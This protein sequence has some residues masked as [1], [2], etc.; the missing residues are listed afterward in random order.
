[1][2]DPIVAI[3]GHLTFNPDTG[4]FRIN[5]W[6]LGLEQVALHPLVGRGFADYAGASSLVKLFLGQ[7]V[8][9][10]W[11]LLMLR[12]GIPVVVFLLLAMFV[13]LFKKKRVSSKDPYLNKMRTAF[14]LAMILMAVTALTVDF[15]DSIWILFGMVIGIRAS[16][17]ELEAK[18]LAIADDKAVSAR[19]RTPK[20]GQKP[21]S[22]ALK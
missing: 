19:H 6:D 3:V 11:L 9:T 17:S 13:P 7:S 16:F 14:S 10:L 22:M 1:M 5:T 20:I 4:N 15:W 2:N 21:Q 18:P 8:D 12:Y